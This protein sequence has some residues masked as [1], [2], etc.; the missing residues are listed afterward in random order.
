MVHFGDVVEIIPRIEKY[1]GVTLELSYE[2]LDKKTGEIRTTGSS[3]H[4][5]YTCFRDVAQVV[6]RYFREVE[7]ASSSLVIPSDVKPDNCWQQHLSEEKILLEKETFHPLN[8]I[9]KEEY[10]GSMEGMRYR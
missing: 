10:S 6:E 1:N 8:Y 5:N 9:K 2:I 7:V 3:K 4:C